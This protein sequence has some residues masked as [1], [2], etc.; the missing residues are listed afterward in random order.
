MVWRRRRPTGEGTRRKRSRSHGGGYVE[1]KKCQAALYPAT[2]NYQDRDIT[3][4]R[5]IMAD[6]IQARR[7]GAATITVINVGDLQVNLGEWF[8]L[9]QRTP[10]PRYTADSTK[11]LRL[12]ILCTHIRLPAISVLVDAGGAVS[13]PGSPSTDSE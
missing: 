13:P 6:Y 7:L 2:E 9:S 4:E 5:L 10:S 11:T 1:A 3:R 12:P 8:D